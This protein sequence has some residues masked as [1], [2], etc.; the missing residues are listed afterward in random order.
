M[1]EPKLN[2]LQLVDVDDRS[3]V[4]PYARCEALALARKQKLTERSGKPIMLE[5][6]RKKEEREMIE[7]QQ[8]WMRKMME[9]ADRQTGGRWRHLIGVFSGRT[10]PPE[11]S[12]I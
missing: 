6:M 12:P 5:Y 8:E 10:S 2:I 11:V 7:Q 3:Q 1:R 4:N 9:S